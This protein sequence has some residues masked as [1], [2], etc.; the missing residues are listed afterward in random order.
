[1]NQTSASSEWTTRIYI[2]TF[3]ITFWNFLDKLLDSIQMRLD[4]TFPH[5][6]QSSLF[7]NMFVLLDNVQ[8]LHTQFLKFLPL[9]FL[10]LLKCSKKN[11]RKW[12][13]KQEKKTKISVFQPILDYFTILDSLKKCLFQ[14]LIDLSI[15][16]EFFVDF[17][18]SCY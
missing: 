13:W 3:A 17:H 9:L 10:R 4:M 7:F 18:G 8:K 11:I 1:M 2:G 14:K 5:V 15:F 6:G 16:R 12:T